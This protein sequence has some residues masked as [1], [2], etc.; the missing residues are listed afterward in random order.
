VKVG[1]FTMKPGIAYAQGLSGAIA[2]SGYTYA[3]NSDKI[4][5]V[6]FPISF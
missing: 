4:I 1:D 2:E 6:D 3:Y 5:F